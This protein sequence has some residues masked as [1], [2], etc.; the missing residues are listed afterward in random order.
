M[1]GSLTLCMLVDLPAC[2]STVT[3]PM[4][5]KVSGHCPTINMQSTSIEHLGHSGRGHSF[6]LQRAACATRECTKAFATY[7][8]TLNL[9]A[10]TLL[11]PRASPKAILAAYCPDKLLYRGAVSVLAVSSSTQTPHDAASLPMLML[12]PH[13]CK[14]SDTWA[15]LAT[16][17]TLLGMRL[18]P[19]VFIADADLSPLYSCVFPPTTDL[20]VG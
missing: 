19:Q 1:L 17:T 4:A 20:I 10:S 7:S 16:V 3:P 5:P 9:S 18:R 2:M 11:E 13:R 6:I 8:S 15:D 14:K 12:L